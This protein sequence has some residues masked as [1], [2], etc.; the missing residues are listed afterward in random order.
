[1][2]PAG[3]RSVARAKAPRKA[4]LA[5]RPTPRV[6]LR[7]LLAATAVAA[8]AAGTGPSRAADCRAEVTAA[9]DKQRAAKAFRMEASVIGP[10]GPMKM[11]VDYGL[12]DRIHQKVLMV[13]EN[14]TLEAVMIGRDGWLNEGQG[15]Q[16]APDEVKEEL[17][18]QLSSVALET[19]DSMVEFD[20]MGNMQVDGAELAAYRAKEGSKSL[21]STAPIP[22]SNET[23]RVIYID[24][25]SGL[26][27]RSVV[28]RPD[29]LDKPLFKAVYSYPADIKIEPPK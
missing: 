9:F 13:I 20:C 10:Q 16:P 26:P 18:K 5:M 22:T 29:K 4:P 8:L 21:K 24:P 28:A 25:K 23:I 6:Q 19:A 2:K 7:A 12:P 14:K 3:P 11:T 15:W 1:M 17:G 27:A